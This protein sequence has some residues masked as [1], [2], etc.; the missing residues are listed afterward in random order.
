MSVSGLRTLP[1]PF[2][3]EFAAFAPRIICCNRNSPPRAMSSWCS[4]TPCVVAIGAIIRCMFCIIAVAATGSVRMALESA[5]NIGCDVSWLGKP[6]DKV[7][8]C[9]VSRAAAAAAAKRAATKASVPGAPALAVPT[10]VR[11]PGVVVVP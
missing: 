1:V 3:A 6:A 2:A 4:F 5:C 9:C 7:W 8:A 11:P 10:E